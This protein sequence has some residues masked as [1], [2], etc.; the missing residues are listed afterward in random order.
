MTKKQKIEEQEKQE[1]IKLFQEFGQY[2]F[3]YLCKQIKKLEEENNEL[4]EAIKELIDDSY[5]QSCKEAW[6]TEPPRLMNI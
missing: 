5:T 1:E 2:S 3:F 6:Y 4:N